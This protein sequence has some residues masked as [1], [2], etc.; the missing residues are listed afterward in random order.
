VSWI[1]QKKTPQNKTKINRERL[2]RYLAISSCGANKPQRDI[3]A[4]LQKDSFLE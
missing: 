1:V 4:V 2:S 3:S